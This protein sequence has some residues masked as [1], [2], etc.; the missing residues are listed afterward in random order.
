M[1]PS[2]VLL[3][4]GRT[5]VM[6]GLTDGRPAASTARPRDIPQAS[7]KNPVG[8]FRLLTSA[9]QKR[10]GLHRPVRAPERRVA[11]AG[12]GM[13]AHALFAELAQGSVDRPRR[14]IRPRLGGNPVLMP[15]GRRLP[16]TCCNSRPARTSFVPWMDAR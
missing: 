15:E 11:L 2:Q 13:N 10:G 14:T 5:L 16:T 8:S 12:P 4:D 9:E 7:A 6:A 3:P 1:V